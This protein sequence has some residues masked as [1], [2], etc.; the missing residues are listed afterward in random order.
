MRNPLSASERVLIILCISFYVYLAVLGLGAFW[1]GCHNPNDR[2]DSN[3]YS[4]H[5]DCTLSGVRLFFIDVS[6]SLKQGH[7]A[8]DAISTAV[9]AFFAAVLFFVTREQVRLTKISADAALVSARAARD[10][11]DALPNLDRAYIFI[12]IDPHFSRDIQSVLSRV[13]RDARIAFQFINHG[14]TPAIIKAISASFRIWDAF[15]RKVSYINEPLAAEIVVRAGEIHPPPEPRGPTDLDT[16]ITRV[17]GYVPPTHIGYKKHS[18]LSD[19][20]TADVVQNIQEG[21]SSLWFYG[22]VIYEDV[23]GRF[24]KTRFCWRYNGK[25]NSFQQYNRGDER[26]NHRS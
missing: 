22:H 21:Q 1:G 11:A 9:V 19:P 24:H 5:E 14:K 18:L 25:D 17:A 3:H 13:D 10:S 6:A 8:I 20:L 15:P 4:N 7:D 26:L 23:F 12:E 16:R 2:Y